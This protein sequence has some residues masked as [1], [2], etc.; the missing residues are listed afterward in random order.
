MAI[1]DIEDRRS[2]LIVTIFD[3]K[4][5]RDRTFTQ[6][7]IKWM[8]DSIQQKFVENMQHSDQKMFLIADFFFNT[9]MQECTIQMV[10]INQFSKILS[11]IVTYLRLSH[12][13]G[14]TG[15]SF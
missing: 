3:T 13:E 15:H 2:F 1:E 11:L 6:F 7:P 8:R 14:Y 9:E 5:N 12:P 4:T 10:R